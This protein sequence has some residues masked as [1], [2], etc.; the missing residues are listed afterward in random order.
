MPT[1]LD[2]GH[3]NPVATFA[4]GRLPTIGLLR[5]GVFDESAQG[6]DQPHLFEGAR[7]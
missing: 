4:L 5:Q 1:R 3:Y 2:E 7:T 6:P